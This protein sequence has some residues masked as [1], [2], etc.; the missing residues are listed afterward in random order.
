M[1]IEFREDVPSR[2]VFVRGVRGQ[3]MFYWLCFDNWKRHSAYMRSLHDTPEPIDVWFRWD[4]S[5]DRG[6]MLQM[7]NAY[8]RWH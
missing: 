2:D 6:T 7:Y 3:W 1:V 8:I 4:C 5:I